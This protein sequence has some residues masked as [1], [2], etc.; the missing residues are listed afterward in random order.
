MKYK[1]V[2]KNHI[3]TCTMPGEQF[4]HLYPVSISYTSPD[5][6]F[7]FS[8]QTWVASVFSSNSEQNGDRVHFPKCQTSPLSNS[9]QSSGHYG[10]IYNEIYRILKK[11]WLFWADICFR[12][13]NYR[14]CFPDSKATTTPRA[15]FTRPRVT[16]RFFVSMTFNRTSITS[17]SSLKRSSLWHISEVQCG[18]PNCS[19]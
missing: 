2:K 3:L 9:L 19:R 7:I 6:N 12:I 11:F 18:K 15:P 1:H 17:A 16:S 14:P 5:S 13:N 8:V 10:Y 4:P